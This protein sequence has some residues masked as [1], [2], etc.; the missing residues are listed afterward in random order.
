MDFL[1]HPER[2]VYL[3]LQAEKGPLGLQV[4]FECL[5]ISTRSPHR[6]LCRNT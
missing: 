5:I 6:A 1:G 2:R 3:A 4:S